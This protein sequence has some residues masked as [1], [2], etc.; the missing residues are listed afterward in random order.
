MEMKVCS[1][2]L[3]FYPPFPCTSYPFPSINVISWTDLRVG[4]ISIVPL[5]D[6]LFT[7]Y[8]HDF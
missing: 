8:N 2:Y 7:I 4:L 5:L 1:V 6:V 3:C